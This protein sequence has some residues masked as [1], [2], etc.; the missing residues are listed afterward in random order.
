MSPLN[1]LH[2]KYIDHLAYAFF[3]IAEGYSFFKTHPGFRVLHGPGLNAVQNVQYLFVHVDG[4]GKIEILAPLEGEQSSPIDSYLSKC[5]PGPYHICYAVDSVEESLSWLSSQQG[6][7]AICNPVP[8]PAFSGRRIAFV[9]N[10]R[11]GLIELVEANIALSADMTSL[12]VAQVSGKCVP[13]VEMYPS[14][15]EVSVS[16]SMQPDQIILELIAQATDSDSVS[17]EI[18]SF[19]Q[20]DNW[21]SLSHSIFHVSFENLVGASLNPLDFPDLSHYVAYRRQFPQ[22]PA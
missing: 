5:G 13:L 20:I 6:W 17:V 15:N 19:D 10:S 1:A 12:H 3:T 7:K 2:L 8:D 22:Q 11:F 9:F 21:D 14:N 18:S 4:I 16:S